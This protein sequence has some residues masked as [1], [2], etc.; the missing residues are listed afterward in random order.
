VLKFL[1]DCIGVTESTKNSS[2]IPLKRWQPLNQQYT[3]TSLKTYTL[4]VRTSDLAEIRV[5]ATGSTAND[6]L[7][8]LEKWTFM[9]VCAL[10]F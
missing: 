9:D 10:T 3:V 6:N 5:A 2:A 4:T 7:Q 8:Q 1:K